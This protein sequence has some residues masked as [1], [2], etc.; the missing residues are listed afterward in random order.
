MGNCIIIQDINDY[1]QYKYIITIILVISSE[2]SGPQQSPLK[3]MKIG[4]VNISIFPIHIF[5]IPTKYGEQY[6]YIYIHTRT[7]THTHIHTYLLLFF[8]FILFFLCFQPY[9]SNLVPILNSNIKHV[10]LIEK[11]GIQNSR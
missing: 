3:F 9:Q 4:H 11:S 10:K 2:T 6:I 1:R 7:Q 5:S 8:I